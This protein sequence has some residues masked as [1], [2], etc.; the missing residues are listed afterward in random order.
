MEFMVQFQED[1]NRDLIESTAIPWRKP[2]FRTVARLHIPVQDFNSADHQQFDESM[3][4]NPWHCWPEHRPVGGINRARRDV[5][6]AIQEF[7]LAQNE[8]RRTDVTRQ[9]PDDAPA[10]ASLVD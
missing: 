10:E 9:V 2:Q 8:H 4:F 7:R 3:T 6:R 1:P 5:M